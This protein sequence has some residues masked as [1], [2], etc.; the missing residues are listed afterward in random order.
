MIG[1]PGAFMIVATDFNTFGA[2]ILSKLIK[3]IAGDP[4]S[5]ALSP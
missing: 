2:A 3:E 5:L 4:F 1:G